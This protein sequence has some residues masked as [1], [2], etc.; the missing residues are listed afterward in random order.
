MVS[1]STED[2]KV[3]LCVCLSDCL[4]VRLPVWLAVCL[5]VCL[6]VWLTVLLLACVCLSVCLSVRL[7]VCLSVR[8][9]IRPSVTLPSSFLYSSFYLFM[10]VQSVKYRYIEPTDDSTQRS[11]PP[12]SYLIYPA[13]TPEFPNKFSV[14]SDLTSR[15]IFTVNMTLHFSFKGSDSIE[16]LLSEIF[17]TQPPQVI[18][19]F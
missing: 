7:F 2:S 14:P 18:S 15:N 12:V 8:L 4:F 3:G 13:Q 10:S 9:S 17:T 19:Y 6:S 5:S 11:F 1:D 16:A